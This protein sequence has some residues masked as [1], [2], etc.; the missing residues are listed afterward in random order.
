MTHSL[1]DGFLDWLTVLEQRH[2]ADLRLSEVTKALRALSSI[3][4]ERRRTGGAGAAQKTRGALDSRG[5]RAAFALF[6]GP[7]HFLTVHAI[8]RALGAAEPPPA[9]ILDIGCGTG[10]AGAAWAVA[11]GGVPVAGFDRDRWAVEEARWTYRSLGLAGRSVSG[12]VLRPSPVRPGSAIVAAYVLNELADDRRADLERKLVEA[13]ARGA[14]T[15]VVEPI[16]KSVTPWWDATARRVEHAGGRADEWRLAMDLPP[17]LQL[18][19]KAAGLDHRVLTARSLYCPP[20][21]SHPGG[22]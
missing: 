8:V 17:L 13:T 9:S 3:Y 10:V 14:R 1:P 4:V 22:A 20:A 15:L 19:D 7:L 12:D 11:A 21:A 5:K 6:Y 2:L 16:A 18:L